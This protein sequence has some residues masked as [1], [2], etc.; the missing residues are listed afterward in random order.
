MTDAVVAFLILLPVAVTFFL[1]SS[2]IQA[3]LALAAGYVIVNLVGT[4][5]NN[6]LMKL[7]LD[8][9]STVDIYSLILLLAPLITLVLTAKTWAGRSSM[10]IQLIAALALGGA[11]ALMAMPYLSQSLGLSFHSSKIWPQL[12]HIQSGLIGFA[13][14]YALVFTWLGKKNRQHGKKHK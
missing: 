12:Q 5:I 13:M 9:L 1:K 10:V 3:I 14:V 2:A 11:W 7:R 4:D 8:G 6:G